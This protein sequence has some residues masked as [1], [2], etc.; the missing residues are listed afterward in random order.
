MHFSRQRNKILETLKNNVV[1]PSTEYIHKKLQ[2]EG[3]NIGIA[4]V[5]RNLNK[6]AEN[7]TI[8]KISGLEES[9]HYD[10]NTH[11]HYH[12]FCNKCR[13]IYD[14]PSDISPDIVK[15]AEQMTGFKIDTHEIVF[16]GLCIDCR[17]GEK[18][19]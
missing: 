15:K 7:G 14:L 13:K 12:F 1:H 10:H 8:K 11:L 2:E 4:T 6:L 9:V 18:D 17:K 3:C 5:Y 19:G 16:H